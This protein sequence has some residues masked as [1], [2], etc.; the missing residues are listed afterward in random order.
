MAY[1]INASA[2]TACGSCE[3]VC[4]TRAVKMKGET[5]IIDATKCSECK[6]FFPEPQCVANCP[7]DCI[8]H[9]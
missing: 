8:V 6:G 3:Y 1:R 5:F 7:A 4:P 2:C 9:A